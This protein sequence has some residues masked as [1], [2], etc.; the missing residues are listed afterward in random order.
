MADVQFNVVLSAGQRGGLITAKV[1][2]DADD[3][4]PRVMQAVSRKVNKGELKLTPGDELVQIRLA[5]VTD[6]S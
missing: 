1:T 4:W 2:A 6:E 5:R 3:P